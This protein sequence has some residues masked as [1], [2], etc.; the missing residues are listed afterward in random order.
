M[1]TINSIPA[2]IL[3]AAS[4]LTASTA[5]AQEKSVDEKLA[6]SL[7]ANG[8]MNVVIVCAAIILAGIFITLW[9]IDRKVSRL[10]KEIGV[11]P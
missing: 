2:V 9:R 1:K 3:A 11:K 8:S 10:E 7:H 4:L 6:Q 5:T